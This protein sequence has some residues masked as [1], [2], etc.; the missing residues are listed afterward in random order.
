[1]DDRTRAYPGPEQTS[2]PPKL[3]DRALVMCFESL[4]GSG[5]GCEFGL[6][7]R[8]FDAEPLGLLRWADLSQD[9]LI[10]ALETRFDGVGLPENTIVFQPD[11]SDEWWTRDTRFWMAMRSFVKV[12][13]VDQQRMTQQV[14]R[15]LQFL[16]RKL[17]EDLEAGEKIFV[18][19]NLKR[20]LTSD[21]ISRLHAAVRAYGESTLFYIRYEDAEHPHGSVEAHAPGLLIGYI[22]RFSHSPEDTSLGPANE[23]LH[24]LCERAYEMFAGVPASEPDP[25]PAPAMMPFRGRK[26]AV[27]GNCQAQAMTNLYRKF[28][29]GRTGETLTYVASYA[30]LT[31][32]DRKAIEQADLVVEQLFDLTQP[33]DMGGVATGAP[34]IFIPMVTAAFLWPFAGQP[35]PSNR[36]YKFLTGGPYGGEAS[37]SYLNRLILAGTDPE[38]AVE[39]YMNLDIRKRTNLDRMFELVMDRQRSRDETAGYRIAEIIEQHFRTEQIFLSPYHPNTR[40]AVALATQFF[41]HMGADPQ[42]VARMQNGTRVTP[43]PK[44]EL[45]LHPAVCKHFGLGFIDPGRRYRFINEGLFTAR[46]YALRYMRYEW[47][48]VLEEGLSLVHAGKL[49]AAY[50]KLVA[51]VA[52]S[53]QSAAAHNA[54]GHLLTQRGKLHEALAEVR[55]ALE[56]EPS[57]VSYRAHRGALLRHLGRLD[58]AEEELRVAVAADPA[59]QQTFILLAHLLRQR[60]RTAEGLDLVR[61]ALALDPYAPR[62]HEELAAFLEA[63][64]DSAGAVAAQRQAIELAP[65]SPSELSRLAGLLGRLGQLEDAVEAARS[66]IALEPQNVRVRVVLSEVLM[67]NGRNL[68]GLNEALLAAVINPDS[69]EA[70]SHLGHILHVTGD[71]AAETALRRAAVLD[72][73]NAHVRYQLSEVLNTAG[74]LKEAIAA[75]TEASELEAGNPRRLVHLARLLIKAHDLVAAE[76]VQ[77]RAVE[78]E[79]ADIVSR[80]VLS[81]ILAMLGRREDALVEAKIAVEQQPNSAHALGHLA[82][83]TQLLGNFGLSEKIY[84]RAVELAPESEHLR[85]QL[86]YVGQ[87]RAQDVA[88]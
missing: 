37:D 43:F 68:E 51:G 35:H 80:V 83:V 62:L 79:P 78:A 26:V 34:R 10:K 40:V 64:G 25:L 70:Y 6:F 73:R 58:D 84:R 81:D 16:R 77:R 63:S 65:N 46:E 86:D 14:C 53:P 71:S 38:E 56:I 75:A 29:A 82:H 61:S 74:R 11:R 20:N 7:Q 87:R 39:T 13:E 36:E 41:H 33:A 27:V 48:E 8:H 18:Y 60:G 59:D 88:A 17:I 54:L 42:D 50:D 45:P 72:P 30:D 31:P 57:S 28:V 32:N 49:D 44:T 66:A 52:R 4:G 19:K 47:N 3:T 5:H 12:A 23:S 24:A 85:Q 69:A 2:S 21:E 67:R 9:L 15:R 22:D 1:M 76:V 55:R